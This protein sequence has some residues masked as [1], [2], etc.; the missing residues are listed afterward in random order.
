MTGHFLA[1][2]VRPASRHIPRAAGRS[3]PACQLLAEWP[4]E[5]DEPT[6]YWLS[7]LPQDTRSKSWCAWP[8]SDG[9]LSATTAS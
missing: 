7:T 9:G 2:R 1:I 5:A 6:G 8:R 3:F 4:S